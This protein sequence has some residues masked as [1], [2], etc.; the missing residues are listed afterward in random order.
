MLLRHKSFDF[1]RRMLEKH[2]LSTESP[3]LHP[4]IGDLR[5]E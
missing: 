5:P 2:V 3:C 4:N 1:G